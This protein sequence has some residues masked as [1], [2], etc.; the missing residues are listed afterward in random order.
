[1]TDLPIPTF[2]EAYTTHMQLYT[3]GCMPICINGV[4]DMGVYEFQK[5]LIDAVIEKAFIQDDSC[6]G[7]IDAW[8][9]FGECMLLAIQKLMAAPPPQEP[10]PID[11]NS[12]ECMSD[13]D[14]D[15]GVAPASS[16]ITT[17]FS[18]AHT[19]L[20]G[21]ESGTVPLS[22]LMIPSSLLVPPL[23]SVPTPDV[24]LLKSTNV[25]EISTPEL[26]PSDHKGLNGKSLSSLPMST[27]A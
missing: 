3:Y 4:V 19:V 11:T 26:N 14:E 9:H 17:I 21:T 24:P 20:L 23:I 10:I 15:V 1:M 13:E 27:I 25:L 2:I 16:S 6:P 5:D 8:H 18:T 12:L 22:T 7:M